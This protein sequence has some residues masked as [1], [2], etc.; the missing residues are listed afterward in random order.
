MLKTIICLAALGIAQASSPQDIGMRDRQQLEQLNSR[1]L[2]SLE[3]R[4]QAEMAAVLADD[5]IGLYGDTA[6]SKQ[7]LL[8]GLKTRLKTRVS[9]E[10]LKID[11]KGDSAVVSAIS[12]IVTRRESSETVA[13][14]NYADFYARRGGE[15]KAIGA[16]VIRLP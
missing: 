11:V 10:K 14:Y 2:K 4:D 15:W 1:W 7:Q 5:F 6:L 3:T 8:E 13:R 12:T 16:R 9:W